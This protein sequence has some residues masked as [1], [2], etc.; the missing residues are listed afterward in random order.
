MLLFYTMIM[1]MSVYCCVAATELAVMLHL[2][3]SRGRNR[4]NT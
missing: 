2:P 1:D 3:A 4:E